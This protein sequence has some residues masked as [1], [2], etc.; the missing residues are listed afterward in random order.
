M[1]DFTIL[2]NKIESLL[3]KDMVVVAIDGGSAS[4]KTTLGNIL[5][6]K[7]NCTVLHMDDFFLRPEQ[8]TPERLNEVGGNIDKERFLKEVLIPLKERKDVFYRKFNCINMKL[9]D[10]ELIIPKKLVIIEGAYSLHPE[11]RYFYNLTVF[12]DNNK[13]L[14]KDRILNRN[15]EKMANRFFNEWIPLEQVY[16]E[17][18]K[19]KEHSEIIIKII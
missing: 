19:I 2:F 8:R 18:L 9:E 5:R 7:Y 1:T 15:T 16:F 12:L 14:Q 13:E 11:L 6:E 17:K 10:P 3:Y 4:G